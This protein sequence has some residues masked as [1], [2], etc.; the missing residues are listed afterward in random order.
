MNEKLIK[1]ES[2]I[3]QIQET[4]IEINSLIDSLKEDLYESNL[5]LKGYFENTELSGVFE[6]NI[7]VMRIKLHERNCYFDFNK[8]EKL[9]F[10]GITKDDINL[11]KCWII[12]TIIDLKVETKDELEFRSIAA[13]RYKYNVV[14]KFIEKS[15]NFNIDFLDNKKGN[16]LS[17]FF[18]DIYNERTT[19]NEINAILDYIDY[20]EDKILEEQSEKLSFYIIQLNNIMKGL[21]VKVEAKKLPRNKD[22]LLFD[23]CLNNF[24]YDNSINDLRKKFY[25]PLLIWWKITTIIPMRPSEFTR[26]LK[27][28]SLEIDENNYYLKINRVKKKVNLQYKAL[29]VLDRIKISKEMYDLINEYITITDY[30]GESETL[31]SYEAMDR[32]RIEIYK[33]YPELRDRYKTNSGVSTKINRKVFS[34]L[35]LGYLLSKFYNEIIYNMYGYN[36]IE[37]EL[38]P[39]DTRHIAFTSM[40]LQGY[41]PVEIAVIGGHRTLRAFDNYTCSV[42][43]YIDSEVISIIRKNINLRTKDNKKIMDI[44]FNM[45]KICPKKLEECLEADIEDES[46][47]YCTAEYKGNSFPCEDEECYYCSKWWCEPTEFNYLKL[48]KIVSKK[49]LEKDNKLKRDLEFMVYLMKEVGIEIFNGKLTINNKVAQSLKR[50]SLDLKSNTKSIINLKY[51]LLDNDANTYQL[52]TDL[53]EMLPT[54]EVNEIIMNKLSIATK[55]N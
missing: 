46:F 39:M 29:P 30:Y 48:E 28:D 33:K 41:S 32:I 21:N 24:F 16:I 54:E 50:I 2:D 38:T 4:C 26:K 17:C 47:G 13:M 1:K 3:E 11:I 9:K 8:L 25:M 51:Q 22:I 18:E 6:E 35:T 55:E 19:Y 23:I 44:I 45:P 7:W 12:E 20:I 43:T 31:L 37:K 5:L 49:L 10:I 52:L 15:Q 34:A 53:E 14:C 42:N 36:C 40:M 27:R